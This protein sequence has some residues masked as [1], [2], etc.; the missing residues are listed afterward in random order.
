MNQV[1]NNAKAGTTIFVGY[2]AA[3]AKRLHWGFTGTDKAGRK[4][5]QQ[6]NPWVLLAAQRWPQIVRQVQAELAGQIFATAVAQNHLD[7]G[8]V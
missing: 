4:Y 2:V 1:I 6:G 7:K 8:G 5:S 3:Y